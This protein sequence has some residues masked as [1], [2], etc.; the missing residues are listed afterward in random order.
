MSDATSSTAAPSPVASA[1]ERI[2]QVRGVDK[3]YKSGHELVYALRGIDLEIYQGEYLSI[4]GPSGSG[5]STLFNMIGALDRPSNG[6]ITVGSVSLPKLASRELSYF[7]CKHIGYVFQSYNLIQSLTALENVLLPLTF[8]GVEDAAAIARAT[9]VLSF[10]G[11][12]D[13]LTHT[14]AELSGGQQQRVAIARALANQPSIL[15]ADE[16]TANLDVQNGAMVIEIFKNL[17]RTFG[18]TVITATHDHKML[19]VSDR[20]L[21]IKNGQVD[22]IRRVKD[23]DIRTGSIGDGIQDKGENPPHPGPGSAPR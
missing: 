13:R 23:M 11:L 1:G 16:P 5:K 14:P 10:V 15:L 12:A 18:V 6:E 22:R 17:S 21:W 4:M 9:E 3:I 20:I 7:R 19:A 2:V 8:L